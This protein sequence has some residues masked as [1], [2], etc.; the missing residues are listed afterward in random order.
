[1]F[2]RC[3]SAVLCVAG[4]WYLVS[5][6]NCSTQ[7]ANGG[8]PTNKAAKT[9]A[10]S[11]ILT[12]NTDRD[13]VAEEQIPLLAGIEEQADKPQQNTSTGYTW[14]SA[15][16]YTAQNNLQ[17]RIP[18]PKGYARAAVSKG[19]FAE[20][21]RNFPLKE[22]KPLVKLYDGRLKGNQNAHYA[23]LDI[24]VGNA[25]LQ[26]C[27]DAVMRLRAEYLYA[28]QRYE[29]IHFNYTNGF[30]AAY[31]QWRQGKRPQIKG[32]NTTWVAK[33][34][35]SNSYASFKQYLTNVF[36]YAGTYSLSKELHS[37]GSVD[38]IK[39]GDV[40]IKGGF[41]GHAVI[42]MDVA[43]NA[44]TG[45]KAFLLAQS[46]MPAQEIH[47]LINPKQQETGESPWYYSDFGAI[48]Q[49]PEWSFEQGSLARFEE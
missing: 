30:K 49:T 17:N 16:S 22:G 10:D 21:L 33:A 25:D 14:L 34:Q 13:A 40:F 41:P 35:A 46:Y 39:A 44:Q 28:A 23:V 31:S 26:Q 32:N 9:T 29:A 24:D 2:Y 27:A 12:A 7:A 8:Q 43:V 11:Q 4:L 15:Q 42:V 38:A 18:P 3:Y 19:S 1:M 36:N 45:K 47:L 5:A 37:V 48:L 20:W 6:A